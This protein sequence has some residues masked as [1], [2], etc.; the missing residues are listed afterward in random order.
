MTPG[1]VFGEHIDDVPDIYVYH[2]TDKWFNERHEVH[3]IEV[4][5][6]KER[7]YEPFRDKCHPDYTLTPAGS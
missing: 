5:V 3:L 7:H 2:P 6:Q 1:W 4:W